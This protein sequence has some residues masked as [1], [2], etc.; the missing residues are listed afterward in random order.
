ML[1]VEA[2]LQPIREQI[3]QPLSNVRDEAVLIALP[4][5]EGE[6]C[7]WRSVVVFRTE[8][9]LSGGCIT[10]K[11]E[12]KDIVINPCTSWLASTPPPREPNSR[13]RR[14]P[15]LNGRPAGDVASRTGSPEVSRPRACMGVG[16]QNSGCCQTSARLRFWLIPADAIAPS[17]LGRVERL[18]GIRKKDV[19]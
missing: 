3:Q 12:S 5:H 18:V 17:R 7:P 1:H 16:G 4:N 9:T 19:E 13:K 8:T 2:D 10:I 14:S 15:H 6:V 11:L